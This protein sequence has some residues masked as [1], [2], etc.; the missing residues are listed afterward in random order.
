MDKKALAPESQGQ[1]YLPL[2]TRLIVITNSLMLAVFCVALGN[3]I[4]AIA[5]PTDQF[6]ALTDVGW[7]APSYLL[8]CYMHSLTPAPIISFQ[9]LYGKFHTLF[10]TKWVFVAALLSSSLKV[11]GLHGALVTVSRIIPLE[12]RPIFFDH[13]GGMYGIDSRSRSQK[14]SLVH[15]VRKLDPLRTMIFVPAIIGLLALQ[16][17][18]GVEYTRFNGRIIALFVLFGVGFLMFIPLQNSNSGTVPVPIRGASA[19]RS[20]IDSIPM[21][22]DNVI[23][24]IL[25]GALTTSLCYYAPFFIASSVIISLG[26]GFHHKL[27]RRRLP[28]A[29]VCGV[30]QNGVAA[31]AVLALPDV[32]VGTAI[33]MFLQML[34]GALFTSVAQSLFATKLTKN[35]A[36]LW[37]PSLDLVAVMHA[38]ATRLLDMVTEE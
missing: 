5:I 2:G 14:N 19:I 31:Q 21:I 36:A 35:L 22:P 8:T 10:N 32:S 23:G 12:K 11:L 6:H 24:I 7:Y 1:A 25:S 26:A 3:T 17:W 33:F 9:L 4:M 16:K 30:Q 13:I 38:G 15:T 29:L 28:V 37:I 34:G 27:H 18:G 20:G